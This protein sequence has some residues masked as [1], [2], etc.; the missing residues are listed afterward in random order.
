MTHPKI[1]EDWKEILKAT[2]FKKMAFNDQTFDTPYWNNYHLIDE[3]SNILRGDS[4]GEVARWET[5]MTDPHTHVGD[6]FRY[7]V[8]AVHL[9]NSYARI[10]QKL[11]ICNLACEGK[12]AHTNTIDL[13][14][15]PE[16]IAT[17][18]IISTS[19]ID[20]GKRA[21]WSEGGYILRVPLDNILVTAHSD[22]GTAFFKGNSEIT[23]L[24]SERDSYGGL[25]SPDHVLSRTSEVEYNEIVLTG[26]GRTGKKVEIA[27][28]F[29]KY[30][31][32]GEIGDPELAQKLC[33]LAAAQSWPLVFI[34]ESFHEYG[35][36]EPHVN[37]V[38]GFF[39]MN[40]DGILYLFDQK[41]S[42][43]EVLQYGG[44]KQRAMEPTERKMFL[45]AIERYAMECPQEGLA[46]LIAAARTIPDEILENRA[47][48]QQGKTVE[49]IENLRNRYAHQQ[50][51]GDIFKLYKSLD[52]KY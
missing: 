11:M 2:A 6:Q 34:P 46:T 15:N 24:Y 30:F 43:F 40:R 27:G 50:A 12:V 33:D 17:K 13:L 8:H 25:A 14:C 39:R 16:L 23:K 48:Y 26:T 42:R 49:T 38:G 21:T 51:L 45:D 29:I 4:A 19:I 28:V 1:N 47:R 9:P 44:M 41:H 18:P 37:V 31:P 32:D 5:S 35:D 36:C 10:S 22:I 3:I 7:V 52:L 20:Q